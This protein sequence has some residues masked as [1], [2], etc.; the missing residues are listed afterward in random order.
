MA[1][2]SLKRG[3]AGDSGG[4]GESGNPNGFFPVTSWG[5]ALWSAPDT[6]VGTDDVQGSRCGLALLAARHL[7]FPFL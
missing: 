2:G 5:T 3:I 6:D 7:R 1:N 4:R